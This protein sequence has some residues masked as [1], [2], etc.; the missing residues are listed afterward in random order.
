MTLSSSVYL[1]ED[2]FIPEA[3]KNLKEKIGLAF[4]HHMWLYNM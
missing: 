3:D 4:T 1:C 2:P